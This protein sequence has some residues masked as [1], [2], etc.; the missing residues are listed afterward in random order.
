MGAFEQLRGEHKVILEVAALM[1]LLASDQDTPDRLRASMPELLD[2]LRTYVD[3]NHHAKEELALF[4]AM[5]VDPMLH[6]L[7]EVLEAEHDEARRM[8]VSMEEAA[9]D[10]RAPLHNA[11]LAYTAHMREHIAKENEMIFDAAE[12]TLGTEQT[13]ALEREFTDIEAAALAPG[14]LEELLAAIRKHC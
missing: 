13:N 7:A 3:R 10:E 2:F 6:A 14:K 5:E 11:A 1:E 9:R 4:P 8:L 12:R